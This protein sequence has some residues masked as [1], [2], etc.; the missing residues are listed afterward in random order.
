MKKRTRKSSIFEPM[1]M[2]SIFERIVTRANMK[3]KYMQ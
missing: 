1:A 2:F 3:C